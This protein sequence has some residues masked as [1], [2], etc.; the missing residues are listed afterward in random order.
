MQCFT[1]SGPDGLLGIAHVQLLAN[2][3]LA[4]VVPSL[5]T[6]DMSIPVQGR[7]TSQNNQAILMLSVPNNAPSP[8]RPTS[9]LLLLEKAMRQDRKCLF[10]RAASGQEVPVHESRSPLRRKHLAAMMCNIQKGLKLKLIQCLGLGSYGRSQALG[11]FGK[12]E[13]DRGSETNHLVP[14]CACSS[15][16]LILHLKSITSILHVTLAVALTR[17]MASTCLIRRPR[18]LMSWL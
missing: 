10:M 17:R 14:P 8:E 6:G 9:D 18:Y 16:C 7:V 5:S 3:H 12:A 11:V 2:K 15:R 4:F 1:S 13:E